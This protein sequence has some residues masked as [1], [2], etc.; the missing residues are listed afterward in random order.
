MVEFFMGPVYTVYC[1]THVESGRCYVG[2]TKKTMMQRWN[3]HV[4][5]AKAKRGRGCHHFWAAIRKYGKDAFEPLILQKCST[6]E[7]ANAYEDYY[8]DLF[9]ARDPLKGFNLAKGG[10][11]K[12]HPIRKNPWNDPKF[13]ETNLLISV[14]NIARGYAPEA[15]AKMKATVGTSE[16]KAKQSRIS[17]EI[18]SRPEVKAKISAAAKRQLRSQ[19]TS[20]KMTASRRGKKI[21]AWTRAKLSAAWTPE[22][23]LAFSLRMKD[24]HPSAETRA[25]ISAAGAGRVMNAVA[26][27]NISMALKG[28]KLGP[29]ARANISAAAKT[30]KPAGGETRNKIRDA[31]KRYVTDETGAITHKTCRVHGLISV[32][33]CYVRSSKKGLTVACKLC[34]K[35]RNEEK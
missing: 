13:R 27:A 16:F 22:R 32:D 9:R 1:H 5:N 23:K 17:K 21:S 18:H 15:I 31:L 19:E 14:G 4:L 12:P 6:L 10:E 25:K 24:H 8:I 11:H 35:Q 3:N 26:R 30:R 34:V 29:E 20:A 2:L 7:V 33:Q 28:R